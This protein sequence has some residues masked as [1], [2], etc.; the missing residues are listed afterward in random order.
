MAKYKYRPKKKLD[1]IFTISII[2]V[3][4][5]VGLISLYYS[6]PQAFPPDTVRSTTTTLTTTTTTL[7]PSI[8]GLIV[9]FKDESQRV[10][11]VGTVNELM[12]T[13]TNI[14]VHKTGEANDS[15]I[16]IF[17]GSKTLDLLLYTDV[18]AIVGERELDI[19]KYTQI[20]L[21]IDSATAKISN[22]IY[23]YV[24]RTF[25]LSIPSK[26]LKLVNEFDIEVNKTSVL[27]L[28]FDVPSILRRADTGSGYELKLTPVAIKIT[29]ENIERGQRPNNTVAV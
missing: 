12:I 9:A 5:V 19:G 1:P 26:E 14:D 21:V 3:L 22:V 28:D 13:V 4:I 2:I 7:P 27:T 23:S 6:L 29:E 15:W 16:N 25:D 17:N 24:N 10:P 11:V 8:G 18:H 20:R